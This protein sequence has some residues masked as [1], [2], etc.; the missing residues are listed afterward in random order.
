M[1]RVLIGIDGLRDDGG[2][3]VGTGPTSS[4]LLRCGRSL[5]VTGALGSWVLSSAGQAGA[6]TVA[7]TCETGAKIE[8]VADLLTGG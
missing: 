1:R 5:R 7:L 6:G 3:G 8:V 2:G 4:G